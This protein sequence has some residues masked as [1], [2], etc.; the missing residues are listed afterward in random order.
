MNWAWAIWTMLFSLLPFHGLPEL[1]GA[2]WPTWQSRLSPAALQRLG[3]HP[4]SVQTPPGMEILWG[5]ICNHE[6]GVS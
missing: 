4:T 5:D 3:G 2:L 6:K 1:E